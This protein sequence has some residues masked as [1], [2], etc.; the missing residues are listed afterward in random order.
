MTYDWHDLNGDRDY[1]P[2]EVNSIRTAAISS[3]GA[4][5]AFLNPDENIPGAEEYSIGLSASWTRTGGGS[6][7]WCLS[8]ELQRESESQP[9]QTI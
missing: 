5:Y 9:S 4:Q 1:D 7:C 6:R 3:G 2:G 8:Q